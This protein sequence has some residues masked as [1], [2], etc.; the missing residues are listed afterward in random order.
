MKK[1]KLRRNSLR[2][3]LLLLMLTAVILVASTYAW[4]T[5]NQTVTVEK[6]QVNVA[7]QNGLQISADG[8]VWS[9]LV[10]KTDLQTAATTYNTLV[11]QFPA[12]LSPVST[13]GAVDNGKLKMFAGA[14]ET[15]TTTGKYELTATAATESTGASGDFIAFD[16]FLKV[17]TTTNIELTTNSGVRL[18]GEG[19]SQGIQNAARIAFLVEGNQSSGTALSTIQAMSGATA[20]NRFIWEPNY[21]VHTAA[22]VQHALGTYGKTISQTGQAII[23]Y[24]GVKAAISTA[25]PVENATAAANPTYFDP[26]P[27][28]YSTTAAFPSNVAIFQL[29]PGITKVRVYMWIEGQDV[30]CENS[31]SG[32]N[33]DF[34]L[35]ITKSATQPGSGG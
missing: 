28:A 2:G 29:Q 5:A 13:S 30:D 6:L 23:G 15:N 10:K 18:S 20:T 27:I 7:A 21:D 34:D 3:T 14:T 19:G 32:A 26:T 12:T 16:I 33:I 8:S 31:A 11:N 24:D 9:A 35:Q 1:Q 25:I 4:F 17:E 22:A